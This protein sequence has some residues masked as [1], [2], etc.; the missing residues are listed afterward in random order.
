MR[1][2]WRGHFGDDYPRDVAG[3][4]YTRVCSSPF[5]RPA[6]GAGVA[7]HLHHVLAATDSD[8][9]A[10]CGIKLLG[11]RLQSGL[12]QALAHLMKQKQQ[13]AQ[14]VFGSGK[15]P[16]VATKLMFLLPATSEFLFLL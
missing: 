5:G 1:P 8:L 14:H 7:W 10:A 12:G 9:G 13:S 15:S 2:R 6:G 3:H 16:A 11:S 4:V